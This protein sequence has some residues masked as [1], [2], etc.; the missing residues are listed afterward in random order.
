MRNLFLIG[1]T[2]IKSGNIKIMIKKINLAVFSSS[3]Y[4]KQTKKRFPLRR[5]WSR[6]SQDILL[7][8]FFRV[9]FDSNW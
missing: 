4:L 8:I 3:T 2:E 9:S 6:K 7:G 5:G 1:Y